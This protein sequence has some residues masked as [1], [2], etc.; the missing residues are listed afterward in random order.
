MTLQEF[1]SILLG[2]N[3]LIQTDHKNLES[4]LVY[5]TSEIGLRWRLL[6]EEFGITI[7]YIKG[8]NNTVADALSRLEFASKKSDTSETIDFLFSVITA[9]DTDLFLLSIA[10]IAN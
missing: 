8:V 6:I 3:I 5:L 10:E 7:K 9:E 4:E 2:Q 1:R